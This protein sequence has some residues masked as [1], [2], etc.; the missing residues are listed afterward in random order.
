VRQETQG[1]ARKPSLGLCALSVVLI[2]A[3]WILFVGGTRRNEMIVGVGVLFFTAASVYRVWR[4]ETLNL[5]F[6]LED[7][8]Q[9]GGSLGTS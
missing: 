7:I 3:L 6:S 1:H 9:H 2:V 4:I 8:A 5:S